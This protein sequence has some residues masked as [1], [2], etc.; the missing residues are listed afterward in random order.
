[1]YMYACMHMTFTHSEIYGPCQPSAALVFIC[2][3]FMRMYVYIY[4]CMYVYDIYTQWNVWALPTL[5][6]P[7]VYMYA[8]VCIRHVA[9]IRY[10]L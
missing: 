5:C 10:I 3:V 9:D 4:V 8:V 6:G 2:M 7:G 1:M